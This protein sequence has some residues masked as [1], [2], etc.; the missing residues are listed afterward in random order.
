MERID[1]AYP[2]PSLLDGHPESSAEVRRLEAAFRRMIG[3]LEA[4]RREAGRAA[5]QAQEHERRR[6]AQ[7]LHDE[8]NQ[9]LTA[10]T[11]RLQASIERARSRCGESSPRRS[12]S[13]ARRW[14]NCSRSRV[15]SVP[16]CLTTMG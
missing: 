14:R 2:D 7:D 11:L 6:I 5:I 12:G 9:A 3:R 13:P 4:E 8:V 1:L 16:R 15:S 10:V